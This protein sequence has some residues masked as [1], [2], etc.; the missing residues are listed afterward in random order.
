MD[1]NAI[2]FRALPDKPFHCS[3]TILLFIF[4][5]LFSVFTQKFSYHRIH[6]V[7]DPLEVTP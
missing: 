5:F 7:I 2:A 4:L 1:T 6:L 3:S